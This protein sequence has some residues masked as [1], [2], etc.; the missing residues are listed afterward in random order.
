[1]TLEKYFKRLFKS[2]VNV[3]V[4]KVNVPLIN[5]LIFYYSFNTAFDDIYVTLEKNSYFIVNS[6][7]KKTDSIMKQNI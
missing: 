1:M 3:N 7:Y 4:K 5:F 6:A 2:D